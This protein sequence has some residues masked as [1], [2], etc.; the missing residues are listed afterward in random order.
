MSTIFLLIFFADG[1][2]PNPLRG[3][4]VEKKCDA[5]AAVLQK[6]FPTSQV[7]CIQVRVDSSIGDVKR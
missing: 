4:A 7:Y 3:Y 5:E 2:Y 1:G 6:Q